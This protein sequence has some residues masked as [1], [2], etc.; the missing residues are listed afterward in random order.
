MRHLAMII[1]S[2]NKNFETV[3]TV[4]GFQIIVRGAVGVERR[5]HGFGESL[6]GVTRTFDS[7]YLP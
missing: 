3:Q 6:S 2:I 7:T 5:M 1:K 4:I